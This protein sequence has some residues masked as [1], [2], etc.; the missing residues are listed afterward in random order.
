VTSYVYQQKSAADARETIS[1]QPGVL[2]ALGLRLGQRVNDRQVSAIILGNSMVI[3]EEARAAGC[4][5][6]RLDAEIK[7]ILGQ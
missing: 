6:S 5:T 7:R 1:A 4:D 3:A 2:E